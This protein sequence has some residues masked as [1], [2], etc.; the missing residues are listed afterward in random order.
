MV[1]NQAYV[2]LC[3]VAGGM[4]MAF[5]YD[6]FRIKR[7]A[8]RAGRIVTFIDDILYWIIVAILI[9]A[10]IYISNE[11]EIR[12]YIVLG[13]LIGAILYILLLSRI[14][15]GSALFVLRV[16]R[17]V[18]IR[19]WMVVTWPIRLL[20]RILAKPA[21][22]LAR[23]VRKA[24]RKAGKAGKHRIGRIKM[25]TRILRNFRRKI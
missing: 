15:V 8:F 16:L 13:I 17:A 6:L 22:F 4:L 2:F 14:V 21:A 1:S 3:S 5:V 9:F 11:G 7:R 25:W 24:L 19:I 12:G 18:L 20:F 10:V 23:L